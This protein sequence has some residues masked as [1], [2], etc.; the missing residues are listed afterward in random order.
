MS[1]P[2][3]SSLVPNIN[4][5]EN[6]RLPQKETFQALQEHAQKCNPA[7]EVGIV[8]PVGC[9]KSG[10]IALAP[11]AYKS[12]R[13]LVIAPFVKIA[14][15]LA[16]DF[17]YSN[18]K[19]FYTRFHV[20][21]DSFPEPV[22]IRG[23]TTNRTDLDAADVV[24]TNIQQLQG[25]E[26]RWLQNLP[27][28]YFDLI[29]FDE[30]HH[31][32]AATWELL[33]LRFPKAQ[34]LN[35]SATPS[36]ADGQQM[37]GEILYSF[38]VA[39]AIKEGYVKDLRALVLNPRTLKYV[40][41][42]GEQE[43][44]VDLDEVRRLG[45]DDADF[46]KSIV[47]SKETLY[48]IVDASIREMR[49]IRAAN[50]NDSRH[51]IIASALNYQ[52]C[53]QI[54]AAYRERGLRA[55]FVHSNEDGKA[56]ER[57]LAKLERHELDVIV[58][59]RK[60]S[61]GFDHPY[62]SVAAVFSIFANLSPFVQFVG[63]IMRA[64]VQNQPGNPKNEGTVVFHAGA[65]IA[66][67]WEDFQ[68]YSAADQDY[69][70]ALLPAEGIDFGD[71]SELTVEPPQLPR[72]RL[73]NT[74]EVRAQTGINVQEIP[75]LENNPEAMEAIATLR[76]LG[77]GFDD[78]QRVWEHQPIQPTKQNRRNASKLE[79][80]A[81]VHCEVGKILGSRNIN[82]KG[83]ELDKSKVKENSIFVKSRLDKSINQ[84]VGIK[85]KQRHELSQE[86]ID[87]IYE[88]LPNLVE[89]VVEEI[90]NASH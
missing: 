89:T 24:V 35:F 15:Q 30:G 79:L 34:I 66:A 7:R 54:V 64:I 62:L 82:P 11:F 90:F 20:L 80:D 72:P 31:S 43:I 32:V 51:K 63:R 57:I 58:Q 49:R 10:C 71:A 46:R 67:R 52:H 56:N 16:A 28:D 14:K 13:A 65:N 33:K 83:R 47:T 84:L 45:E 86:Q 26:N 41:R 23:A 5:N 68:Q 73:P 81:R 87:R 22:E 48:T 25:E 2:A 88:E 19:C 4:G 53:H 60:L 27:N 40:R 21:S 12:R 9:G 37:A 44:E 39:R 38:S 42:E 70:Q 55:D 78:V 1:R 17:D 74:V 61:E 59:V 69:Y 8:L 3:F 50:N 6:L 75:L 29:I 85:S 76:R 77:Y 18:E 36:R